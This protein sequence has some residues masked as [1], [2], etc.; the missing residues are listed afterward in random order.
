MPE[1]RGE[2]AG[3]AMKD[4]VEELL[5]KAAAL[6]PELVLW[7][8]DEGVWTVMDVLCHVEEFIPYWTAQVKR[9]I[10]DPHHAWG[11]DHTDKDRLAAVTDTSAREMT[12]VTENIRRAAQ[13]A[14]DTLSKLTD[15]ELAREAASRNPRWGTK[16]AHFIVDHLLIEH[17]Q[18]HIGQ[19]QR[20]AT[21]YWQ[22]KGDA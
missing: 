21:Q 13:D 22:Q 2:N 5:A 16:P 10:E 12:A 11:R 18:K 3:V 9:M 20:N 6:P 7:K 15:D 14:S 17:V 19:I 4:A 1:T 8:P